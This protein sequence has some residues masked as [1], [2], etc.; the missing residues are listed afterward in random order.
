MANYKGFWKG[1]PDNNVGAP[2]AKNNPAFIYRN[3]LGP[4][5][6]VVPEPRRM[7]QV[8]D[9]WTADPY[10]KSFYRFCNRYLF[11]NSKIRG[12]MMI[13]TAVA[14]EKIFNK[15]LGLLV[16]YNNMECTMEFAYR[17]EKEWR[18]F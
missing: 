16:R 2:H 5:P 15:S 12:F 14:M 6:F 13:A 11:N 3:P 7:P 8:Y 9:K 18:D 4:V 10:S 1:Y 17:K